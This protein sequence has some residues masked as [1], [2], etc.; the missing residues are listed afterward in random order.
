MGQQYTNFEFGNSKWGCRGCTA[1]GAPPA[2]R[3]PSRRAAIQ[4]VAS[5]APVRCSTP[6]VTL[7]THAQYIN[8]RPQPGECSH[9]SSP[10]KTRTCQPLISIPTFLLRNFNC[11]F[12]ECLDVNDVNHLNS[13][14]F[15]GLALDVSGRACMLLYVYFTVLKCY[16]TDLVAFFPG[17]VRRQPCGVLWRFITD[18]TFVGCWDAVAKR[19]R[20]MRRHEMQYK[21]AEG[22]GGK[23]GSQMSRSESSCTPHTPP[24]PP[25][26]ASVDSNMPTI[27]R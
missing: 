7:A 1:Q 11:E 12:W 6:A 13:W 5:A 26:S 10:T 14:T 19:R 21:G 8:R 24:G 9:S 23:E 15:S 2:A 18:K 25:A 4:S 17:V 20:R 27:Y 16:E 22:G 3:P